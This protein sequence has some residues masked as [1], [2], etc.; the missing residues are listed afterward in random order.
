MPALNEI[1]N[2][3]IDLLKVKRNEQ[4]VVHDFQDVANLMGFEGKLDNKIN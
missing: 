3:F 2:D 4:N 1:C